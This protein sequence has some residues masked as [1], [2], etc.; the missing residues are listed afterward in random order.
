MKTIKN[1]NKKT[2][3]S[4][5]NKI[6]NLNHFLF[7]LCFC[8]L[9]LSKKYVLHQWY[10]LVKRN[11]VK[12]KWFKLLILFFIEC[13][14]FLFLFFIVF[15]YFLF[16]IDFIYFLFIIGSIYFLFFIDLNL[17]LLIFTMFVCL[18]LKRPTTASVRSN[19]FNYNYTS[20]YTS[21]QWLSSM[22]KNLFSL[23]KSLI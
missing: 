7:Q 15:N 22:W 4:I 14:V 23:F 13:N 11:G 21:C 6:N 12:R 17:F 9:Y 16:F 3:H 2:L 18:I 20:R 5:K 8:L 1:K 19:K 10:I